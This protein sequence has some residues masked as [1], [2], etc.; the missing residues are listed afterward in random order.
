MGEVWRATDTKL[1]REVAIKVISASFAEDAGRLTRFTREAQ[2]LASLNH[3]NIAAIYGVEE[4]ALVMELVEGPT[5]AE[6][7]AQGPIPLD[8]AIPIARQTAEALEYAHERG[9]VHRDLK[10]ANIKLTLDGRVKVLDFGL[11]KALGSESSQQSGSTVT[12]GATQIGMIMGTPAYMSPEQAKG[13]P[14]DQRTD[15]WAFGVVLWEMLTGR[16]LFD[17]EAVTEILAQVLTQ[18]PDWSQAPPRFEKLLRSCLRKDPRQRLRSIGDWELLLQDAPI[19]PPAGRRPSARLAWALTAILAAAAAWGWLRRPPQAAAPS[20]S[21]DIV[22][23]EGAS[24]YLDVSSGMHAISPDGQTLAFIATSKGTRHIW[25]RPLD[26]PTARPLPGTELAD[27]LFWSPEGRRLGFTAGNSIKVVDILTGTIKNLCDSDNRIRGASWNAAGTIIFGAASSPIMRVSE[28]GGTPVLATV[29]APGREVTHWFPQFLPD[30]KRFLYWVRSVGPEKSGVYAGSL[31]VAPE[32][33][34]RQQ[35]LATPHNAVYSARHLLF[36]RGRTLFAQ[37]FD[38]DRLSLEGAAAPIADGVASFQLAHFSVSQSGVLTWSA[39]SALGRSVTILSRDGALTET[40][41]KPD[42]FIGL[43]LSPDGHSVALPLLNPESAAT[44]LWTMDLSR[45]VLVR[46]TDD[47]GVNNTPVFSPDG[48]TIVFSSARGGVYR[49]Y[50]RAIAGSAS[51]EPVQ[52]AAS[53]QFPSDWSRDGKTLAYWEFDAPGHSRLMLLPV[54]PIGKPIPLPAPNALN[55]SPRLSPS[56]KWVAF[57]SNESGTFEI[58]VQAPAEPGA[59]S[60]PK[61]RISASGGLNPAWSSDGSELFFNTLD[62]R[63]MTV[64][65]QSAGGRFEAGAPRQLFALG[66]TSLFNGG[67][68]WEPIGNGQRFVVLRSAPPTERD[69]RIHI[70]TNWQASLRPNPT[71]R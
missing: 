2:V 45:G 3:P 46:L 41:G 29:L 22:P 47:A 33:Q 26:V 28:D 6:R 15:I 9:I 61:I 34:I 32:K 35:I 64:P 71:T 51:E 39:A 31:D 19:P 65:I 20:Y 17:G 18:E 62:D 24:F 54:N 59:D 13:K 68:Y 55:V 12:I 21:L 5:L 30:G 70:L 66:G 67:T 43:R 8:E 14:V 53:T 37:P 56:G 16:P 4:R 1:N 40:L 60:S 49:M 58:Y 25:L 23:P 42:A 48:K 50:R 63:L 52:P 57:S 7:V 10:P 69:N 11:A 44:D 38:V 36:L 27:G